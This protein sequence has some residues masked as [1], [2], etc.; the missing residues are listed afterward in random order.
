MKGIVFTEFIDMVENEFG[1]GMVD[2]IIEDSNLP[3]K[4]IYTSVGTY[5]HSEIVALLMNLSKQTKIDS[6]VLLKQFGEYLFG[7]FLKA[8]PHFFKESENSID[9]LQSIDNYIH[10]EVLKLY[11][12]AKLPKFKTE[13]LE[14]G[15]LIMTYYS[16][17]KMSALAA[18]LIEKSILHYKDPFTV[19]I[20]MVEE[21]GSIAKFTIKNKKNG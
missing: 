14:D 9:F 1:Y 3:S 16:E 13:T 17:R 11:P 12:D 19:K 5:D 10:V 8:Y 4:G 20:E 15:S 18:G 2:Q 21:D 7:T 6:Q